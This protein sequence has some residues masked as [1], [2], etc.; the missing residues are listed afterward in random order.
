MGRRR[1]SR[2]R[3]LGSRRVESSDDVFLHSAAAIA[4]NEHAT[5]EGDVAEREEVEVEPR[6][7]SS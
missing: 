3:S 7:A 2:Q 6:A 1:G 5:A 4:N